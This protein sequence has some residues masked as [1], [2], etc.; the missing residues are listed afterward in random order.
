MSEQQKPRGPGRLQG[1]F[2]GVKEVAEAL[3][4]SKAKVSEYHRRGK[5]PAPAFVIAAGPVWEAEDI[6]AYSRRISVP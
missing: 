5:L 1:E 6:D 3:G 2:M 4:W